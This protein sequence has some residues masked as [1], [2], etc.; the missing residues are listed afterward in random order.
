MGDIGKRKEDH[1]HIALTKQVAMNRTTG[2]D[3]VELIH[4]ALPEVDFARISLETTFLSHPLSAP[5][6]ISSMTGGTDQG[7]EINRHLAEAAR[8]RGL[9]MAVGSQRVMLEQPWTRSS[10]T[11]VREVA[12]EIVLFGNLGAVQLNYGMGIHA[13]REAIGAI[14]ADGLFLH[15]NPLQEAIQPEG[16]TDFLGLLDKIHAVAAQLPVPVLIKEVGCGIDPDIA[17]ALVR[18]NVQGIDVSGAGGTSWAQIEGMRAQDASRQRL[19]TVFANWGINTARSLVLCR[20]R[21]P[22]L[23]LIA[24]GGIRNGLDAAKALALGADLIGIAH[25]LL[26]AAT[27]ST[28]EVIAVLDQFLLELK[29]AMFLTGA[30]S[31][32][33]LRD[34]RRR[35]VADHDPAPDHMGIISPD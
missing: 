23:P 17:E 35:M 32:A 16:N 21:L 30:G 25:P 29:V 1:I 2:F 14:R 9:A 8:E 34:Q 24:S 10:F 7:R 31:L 18:C 33:D 26:E 12:P 5:V 3:D 11:V 4:R 27:H 13:V 28:E 6:L 20:A 15:L 22:K 19:A